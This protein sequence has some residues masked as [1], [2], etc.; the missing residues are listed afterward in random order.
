[1]IAAFAAVSAADVQ[2]LRTEVVISVHS[3][4]AAEGVVLESVSQVLAA[5][6][7]ALRVEDIGRWRADV[8]APV[9]PRENPLVAPPGNSIIENC[10]H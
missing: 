3:R 9:Q 10:S 7:E 2:F 6:P 4:P 8:R 1:M 5:G